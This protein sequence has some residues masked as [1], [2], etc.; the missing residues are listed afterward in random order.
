[1]NDS[2]SVASFDSSDFMQ[3]LELRPMLFMSSM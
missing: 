2:G 3:A 1:M